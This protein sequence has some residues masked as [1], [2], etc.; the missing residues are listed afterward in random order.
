MEAVWLRK[1]RD[2]ICIKE[3]P[4]DKWTCLW[5]PSLVGARRNPSP[6]QYASVTPD[7]RGITLLLNC[8][9]K[10]GSIIWN[11]LPTKTLQ[12]LMVCKHSPQ[13]RDFAFFYSSS[14]A[15]GQGAWLADWATGWRAASG[16]PA[17]AVGGGRLV[18]WVAGSQMRTGLR[19]ASSLAT[20]GWPS[21]GGTVLCILSTLVLEICNI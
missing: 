13:S 3:A 4:A 10:R 12:K 9:V 14:A 8:K 16:W 19:E 20:H 7:C 15:T 11:G 21:R 17:G 5:A 18:V 1:A 2:R 6:N